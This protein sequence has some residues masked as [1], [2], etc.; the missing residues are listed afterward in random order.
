MRKKPT[1]EIIQRI[2]SNLDAD[3]K[4]NQTQLKKYFS[5]NLEVY[6]IRTPKQR[7]FIKE[8]Y[9]W[10]EKN[11]DY[12]IQVWDEVWNCGSSIEELSQPL[13]WL[14]S[15]KNDKEVFKLWRVIKKWVKRLDNWVHS[16]SLSHSYSRC[17]EF[18]Q[19]K[20]YP[21]LEKWN[22]YNWSWARRQSIVSLLY[23]SRLRL[24]PISSKKI[25]P[26]VENLIFDEDHFVQ[27][28]LG[29][30]LR[31]AYNIYPNVTYKFIK[32]NIRNF[33][34]IAYVTSTEKI[35][36]FD[37]EQLKN[38]RVKSNLRGLIV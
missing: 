12:Q 15:I 26:L 30:T 29:W 6:G 34:S 27:R 38:L 13:F 5:T 28:G 11:L 23:Y 16:D 14:Q 33:S 10:S 21:Q 25:F 31:E 36:Y 1:N 3:S 18:D 24:K 32:K 19:N 22:N 17:L 4:N 35:N 2:L 7:N 20:V 9:T 8:G 37:K